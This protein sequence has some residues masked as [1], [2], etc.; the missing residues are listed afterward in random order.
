[1]GKGLQTR[2]SS[3][4]PGAPDPPQLRR[5]TPVNRPFVN[6]PFGRARRPNA[7][8]AASRQ[9]RLSTVNATARPGRPPRTAGAG[10]GRQVGLRP[11]IFPT[12]VCDAGW[13]LPNLRHSR[14]YSRHPDIWMRVAPSTPLRLPVNLKSR[15]SPSGSFFRRPQ[16]VPPRKPM[17][18]PGE[19]APAYPR[20]LAAVLQLR[21]ATPARDPT[22][23]TP[24]P[25]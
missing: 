9:P 7:T 6:R 1:V 23:W 18:R 14:R 16:P 15:F 22:A 17:P 20:P 11:L 2:P 8:G 24:P 25:T 4:A 21:H 3:G 13:S 5:G 19:I 10:R 12:T